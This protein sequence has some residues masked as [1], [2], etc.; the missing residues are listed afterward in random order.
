MAADGRRC[1]PW[2]SDF[3]PRP[4]GAIGPEESDRCRV[5]DIRHRARWVRDG[6][7]EKQ[8]DH[9]YWAPMCQV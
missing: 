4:A 9:Q 2:R 5:P 8:Q 6:R 1:L 7:F 3:A